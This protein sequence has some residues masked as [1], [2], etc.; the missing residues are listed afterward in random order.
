VSF[1]VEVQMVKQQLRQ[2]VQNLP[3]LLQTLRVL[4]KVPNL[5]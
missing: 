3:V 5:H 2:L 4:L 1:L